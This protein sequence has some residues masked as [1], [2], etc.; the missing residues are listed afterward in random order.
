MPST[1]Y[2]PGLELGAGVTR[3]LELVRELDDRQRTERA[4]EGSAQVSL[5]TQEGT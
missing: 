1:Y 5:R 3:V 2:V 4:P